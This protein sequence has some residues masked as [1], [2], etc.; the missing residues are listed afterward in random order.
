MFIKNLLFAMAQV[1]SSLKFSHFI[2]FM[3]LVPS[4]KD[5]LP[6]SR[7]KGG[8]VCV[9]VLALQLKANSTLLRGWGDVRQIRRESILS[10]SRSLEVVCKA[11]VATKT[12]RSLNLEERKDPHPHAFSLTKKIARFTDPQW[13]YEGHLCGK[14]DREGLVKPLWFL[15]KGKLGPS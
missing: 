6:S 7:T 1:F 11:T 12:Q 5:A 8:S 3:A 4:L 9:D 15:N 2:M 13:P 10:Y 14:I